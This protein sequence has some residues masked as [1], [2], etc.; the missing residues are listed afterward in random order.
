MAVTWAPIN[1]STWRHALESLALIGS[2]DGLIDCFLPKSLGEGG[3]RRNYSEHAT[4]V[5]SKQDTAGVFKIKK[6][7][8]NI[9]KLMYIM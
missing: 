1:W 4:T 8:S 7:I 5:P 9:L 2:S 6:G 3:D